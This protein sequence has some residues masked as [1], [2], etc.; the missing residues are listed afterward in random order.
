[1][2]TDEKARFK[3]ALEALD[4]TLD[5]R[6]CAAALPVFVSLEQACAMLKAVEKAHHEPG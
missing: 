6:D 4:L 2:A 1:M 3:A 5:D